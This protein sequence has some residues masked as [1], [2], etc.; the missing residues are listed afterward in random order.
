[1]GCYLSKPQPHSDADSVDIKDRQARLGQVAL[2]SGI[3]DVQGLLS[4]AIT[5]V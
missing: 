2:R 1:M 3:V 5:L 4:H